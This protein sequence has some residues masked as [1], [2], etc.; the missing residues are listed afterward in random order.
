MRS[1]TLY[2]YFFILNNLLL[3]NDIDIEANNR[4]SVAFFSPDTPPLPAGRL[5]FRAASYIRYYNIMTTFGQQNWIKLGHRSENGPCFFML[6]ICR[7]DIWLVS[8][9]WGLTTLCV[10][11]H[12]QC[13]LYYHEKPKGSSITSKQVFPG[14]GQQCNR[15]I[16]QCCFNVGTPSST[17]AQHWNSIGWMPRV[18]C[19]S[20]DVVL[21]GLL[22]DSGVSTCL[23]TQWCCKLVSVHSDAVSLSLYIVML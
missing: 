16:T 10:Q 2:I 17:L 9:C 4:S 1:S 22:R 14:F 19:V 11:Y 20:Y 21:H 7:L 23:C 18:C 13:N 12:S 5:N 8:T 15:G 6:V 3:N